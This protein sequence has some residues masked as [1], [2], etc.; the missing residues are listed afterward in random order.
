MKR[1]VGVIALCLLG[2]SVVT[3]APKLSLSKLTVAQ[4]Q[5]LTAMLSDA[6]MSH[7]YVPRGIQNVQITQNTNAM[8]LLTA[9]ANVKK[10]VDGGVFDPPRPGILW[11]KGYVQR[12]AQLSRLLTSEQVQELLSLGFTGRMSKDRRGTLSSLFTDAGMSQVW[13]PSGFRQVKV[14]PNA[15]GTF[16]V[17]LHANIKHGT[18]GGVLDPPRPGI[19]WDK[20]FRFRNYE[21]S[22]VLSV[23]ELGALLSQ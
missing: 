11:D 23:A 21:L 20:G 8:Y 16:A 10:G 12:S 5:Q 18:Q 4:R 3:A 2:T 14:V 22:R 1:L 6:G 17:S 15:D 13:T 9:Q 7:R 19:V